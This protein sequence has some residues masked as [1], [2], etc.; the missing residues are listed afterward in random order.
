M[1]VTADYCATHRLADGTEVRLR[2]LGRADREKLLA[3]FDRLSPDSRYRRF[4]TA[5]PRLPEKLLHRL[6]DT[7]GWNHLAIGA[8][9]A[10]EDPTQAEG[11]G[12][13]RFIRLKDAPD[14]AEAAVTVVDHMQR[15]GLGKLLVSTLAEAARERGI[16]HFRAEV[17]RTNDAVKAL[18]HDLDETARPRVDDSIATYDLALPEPSGAERMTGPLYGLLRLAASGLQVVLRR[19]GHPPGPARRGR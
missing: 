18:L 19:L 2:L 5:M 7:D 15:R 6:L 14:V 11:V 9:T 16:T 13:A 8:E 10:T 1:R 12:V 17:L 4:F 3:A